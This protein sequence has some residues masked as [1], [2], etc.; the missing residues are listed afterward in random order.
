[1]SYV[2]AV[3]LDIVT[4]NYCMYCLPCVLCVWAHQQTTLDAAAVVHTKQSLLKTEWNHGQSN[5]RPI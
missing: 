5:S 3:I 2:T 1:M 4:S